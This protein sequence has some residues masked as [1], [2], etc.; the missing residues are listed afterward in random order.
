MKEL[1]LFIWQGDSI[2]DAYHDDGTL[3]V[4]ANTAEEAR[5]IMMSQRREKER[6]KEAHE[7][8]LTEAA[9]KAGYDYGKDSVYHWRRNDQDA[10]VKVVEIGSKYPLATSYG[11]WDGSETALNRDPDEVVELDKPKFIAFNGG[12]YD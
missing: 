5:E 4:L 12:G 7:K 11:E 9:D 3:V 6:Q 1:K 10:M 8:E 2:S